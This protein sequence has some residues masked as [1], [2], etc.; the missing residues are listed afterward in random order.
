MSTNSLHF[1]KFEPKE[2]FNLEK[3]INSIFFEN[4]DEDEKF[5]INEVYDS[6]IEGYYIN[7]YNSR[8]LL[9]NNDTNSLENVVVKKSSIVPFSID[10][11]KNILD[12]W[13]NRNSVIRIISKIGVLLDHKVN[14]DYI[15]INLENIALNLN[16]DLIKIGKIKI[17]NYPIERDIIAQCTLDLKNHSNAISIVKKYSKDLI[18]LSLLIT[19]NNGVTITMMIYKSG[20]VVIYKP[21]EEI[22]QETLDL[23]RKICII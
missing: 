19:M 20:S 13:G 6:I 22:S 1:I 21:K 8:E 23:I 15:D 4:D 12:I 16:Y 7:Y 9:F 2:K 17:D 11:S 14:L 10:I 18:Q 5:L 3:L